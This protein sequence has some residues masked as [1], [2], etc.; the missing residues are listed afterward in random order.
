[1]NSTIILNL[2]P[3]H[4]VARWYSHIEIAGRQVTQVLAGWSV[5]APLARAGADQNLSEPVSAAPGAALIFFGKGTDAFT[6]VP[7]LPEEISN[8]P[9]NCAKRSLIPR[10]PTPIESFSSCPV[11]RNAS[12]IPLPLSLIA[13]MTPV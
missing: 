7:F 1:M 8:R 10:I 9:P 4:W 6:V 11:A 12:G 5:L 3:E 13:R 2:D